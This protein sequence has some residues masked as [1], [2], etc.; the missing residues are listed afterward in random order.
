MKF[1]SIEQG[2]NIQQGLF[3]LNKI[4]KE[5]NATP[6]IWADGL[7]KDELNTKTLVLYFKLSY[8]ADLIKEARTHINEYK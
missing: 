5:I 2:A 4:M 6:E 3:T 1:N 8:A 7:T